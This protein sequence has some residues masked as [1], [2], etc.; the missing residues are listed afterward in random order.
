M[1]YWFEDELLDELEAFTG[2]FFGGFKQI[3]ATIGRVARQAAPIA[4]AIPIPQ[5]QLFGD[6]AD[7]IGDVLAGVI[8]AIADEW[9]AGLDDGT[10]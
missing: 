7:L 8:D 2:E 3:A 6:V 4:T 10:R 9:R 1:C 5:A